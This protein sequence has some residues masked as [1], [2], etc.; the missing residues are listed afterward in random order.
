MC[1]VRDELRV[2]FWRNQPF[3]AGDTFGVFDLGLIKMW[4][5]IPGPQLNSTERVKLF[6]K[7]F[8]QNVEG[9]EKPLMVYISLILIRI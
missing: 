5:D 2:F 1:T 4:S 7:V 8:Q 3:Y 6:C 9:V